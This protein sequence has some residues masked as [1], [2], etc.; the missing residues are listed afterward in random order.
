MRILL[1]ANNWVAWQIVGW[2]RD[3]GAEIVGLVIHPPDK[4]K[5]GDEIIASA[6]V[7]SAVIFDR[8]TL[9][10]PDT[11]KAIKE[12][13]ADLG[14][15]LLFDYILRPDLLEVL[16]A[17]VINLHPSYLPYNRGQYPNVWSIVEGTPAGYTSLS[18][19]RN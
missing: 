14:L 4:R 9:R 15:S 11:M 18:R 3:Q 12:L 1:F 5:Y 6:G 13:R 17:G 2:L 16:P 10:Q 7:D 8:A 19:R